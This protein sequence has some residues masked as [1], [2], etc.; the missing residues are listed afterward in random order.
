MKKVRKEGANQILQDYSCAHAIVRFG[1]LGT[2]MGGLTSF[3]K[4]RNEVPSGGTRNFRA[5]LSAYNH[6]WRYKSCVSEENDG[7]CPHSYVDRSCDDNTLRT[8]NSS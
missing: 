2:K 8:A 7:V 6:R 4:N 3:A 1:M 5:A